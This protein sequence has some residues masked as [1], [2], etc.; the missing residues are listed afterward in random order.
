MFNAEL[1]IRQGKGLL[2]SSTVLLAVD[3]PRHNIG[4]GSATLN[5]LL[6][7][8]EY[9][10]AQ[11]NEKVSATSYYALDNHVYEGIHDIYMLVICGR[12]FCFPFVYNFV[13]YTLI[14]FIMC[15]CMVCNDKKEIII[16]ARIRISSF[17]PM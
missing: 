2:S 4:S 5:A 9:L 12:K 3:D 10:A 16:D 8:T 15:V 11:N 14:S 7:V 17:V 13:I 1:H 6:C